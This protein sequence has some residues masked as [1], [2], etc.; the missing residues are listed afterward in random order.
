M[1]HRMPSCD[2]ATPIPSFLP[3]GKVEGKIKCNIV[4]VVIRAAQ[5]EE[6]GG[7]VSS[8]PRRFPHQARRSTADFSRM[9]LLFQCGT[10]TSFPSHSF[11]SNP[12]H[13]LHPFYVHS[14]RRLL[15]STST[16]KQ[17][18]TIILR[19]QW[20]TFLLAKSSIFRVFAL[21]IYY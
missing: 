21:S 19:L 18:D 11:S 1:P 5:I 4:M 14:A 7:Y 16:N 13:S 10:L 2:L 12:Q 8:F 20:E 3:Q 9:L 6:D 15:C 17:R